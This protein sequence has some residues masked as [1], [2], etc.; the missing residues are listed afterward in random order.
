M[1]KIEDLHLAPVVYP[2]EPHARDD[3]E[4]DKKVLLNESLSNRLTE[5]ACKDDLAELRLLCPWLQDRCR[6]NGAATVGL[7]HQH[8]IKT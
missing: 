4:T 2:D 8:Q 3:V 6:K 7:I 1:N 5:R